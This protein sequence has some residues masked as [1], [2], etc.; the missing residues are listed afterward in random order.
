MTPTNNPSA[1]ATAPASSSAPVP[2]TAASTGT[3]LLLTAQQLARALGVSRRTLTTWDQRGIIPSLC[4]GRVR[5]YEL[6]RVRAALRQYEQP[7]PPP[8][9]SLP[10]APPLPPGTSATASA[11]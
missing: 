11:H 5:R 7:Q 2:E 1:S 8:H 10:P 4:V 3:P 6:D 9:P